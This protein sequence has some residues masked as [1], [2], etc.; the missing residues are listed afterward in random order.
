MNRKP[1]FRSKAR[2]NGTIG[3]PA[4]SQSPDKGIEKTAHFRGAAQRL[5]A[6]NH[7][8]KG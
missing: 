4:R 1:R 8:C 5:L 7:V 3:N 2:A 6:I